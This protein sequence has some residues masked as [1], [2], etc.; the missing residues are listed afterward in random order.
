MGRYRGKYSTQKRRMPLASWV[1]LLLAVLSLSTGTAAAYLATSTKEV[2]NSFQAETQVNPVVQEDSFTN[3]TSTEKTNAYVE[4]GNP[5]YSVY[6]R[7]AIVI[8]WKDGAGNVLSQAPVEGDY[9]LS[10]GTGWKKGSDGYYYYQDAVS[11][12]GKT[13]PLIISCE[14]LTAAPVEGYSLSVD[15]ITQTIQALGKTDDNSKSAAQDAWGV[16]DGLLNPVSAG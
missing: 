11:S 9:S 6:V 3:G 5:G 15:I 7:A 13:E 14:P 16:P 12:G 1:L 2:K 8:T 4:V 10:I